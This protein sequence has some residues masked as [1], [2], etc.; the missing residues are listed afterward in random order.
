[1]GTTHSSVWE[2]IET[3]NRDIG[4]IFSLRFRNY[5]KDRTFPFT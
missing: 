1:M 4:D 5:D 2:L 3:D